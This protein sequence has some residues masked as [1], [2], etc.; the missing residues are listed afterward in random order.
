[1]PFYSYK[2]VDREGAFIKGV[3][4]ADD[5][6]SA[7]S[8]VASSGLSVI[9]MK[10]SSALVASVSAKFLV[11]KIRRKE[12]IEF[13]NNL[14]VMLRAGIPLLTALTDLADTADNRYFKQHINSIRSL[15]EFGSRFSEAIA[16]HKEIFPDILIR[17]VI[18]G[19]E[20]GALDRSL[21]DVA[22][23]LQRMED[24]AAS[25]KRALIYPIFAIV[26]TTGALL[27]WLIYVLPNVIG[28]FRDSAAML[29]LPTRILIF[30][31]RF[32]Q[33]YWYLI[34]L[35]PVIVF[36][37]VKIL[38]R[39]QEIRYYLDL[40]KLKLPVMKHITCNRLLAIF[41]EQL[42]ILTVAGIP[43]NRSFSIISQI[44]GNDVYKSAMEEALA[45]IAAGS[46]ISDALRPHRVFP[47]IVTRMI[48][49]GESSGTLDEQFAYLSAYYF[50]RL[51]DVSEKLG[52]MIEPIIIGVIGMMFA[53]I[54][55]G[56]LFPVYDL[57]TKL[58]S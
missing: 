37:L 29:P 24:L 57:I 30:M 40:A 32:T 34:L 21:A 8:S 22:A 28:I 11:R 58:G 25:I 9:G 1:M 33:S 14:A 5:M 23:H 39:R 31:S 36:L 6:E 17:L 16:A 48:S 18:I 4:E 50:K 13:S 19:E 47:P 35:S 55:I 44:I 53:F 54:V 56:L 26:T 3:I 41:S 42:R 20:T 45:K 12:I 2:A 27:F 15:I 43:I 49:A 51:D 10:Q 52:K 7:Y 38:S 46:R